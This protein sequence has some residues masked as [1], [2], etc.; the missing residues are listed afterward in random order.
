MK[1]KASYSWKAMGILY[2]VGGVTEKNP[3]LAI[4]KFLC[5]FSTLYYERRRI[6]RAK[7][8]TKKCENPSSP[9]CR[10]L[11]WAEKKLSKRRSVFPFS[12]KS[13]CCMIYEEYNCFQKHYIF[14]KSEM[15]ECVFVENLLQSHTR[16][17]K[18]LFLQILHPRLCMMYVEKI[19]AYFRERGEWGRKVWC[20]SYTSHTV[21]VSEKFGIKPTEGF[22]VS[23]EY[24]EDAVGKY[25]CN[26]SP[27]IIEI[28]STEKETRTRGSAN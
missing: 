13:M 21:Y 9:S 28:G 20:M 18:R 10:R 8:A 6:R 7:K 3:F 27:A 23:G 22:S 1:I 17:K 25:F 5:D 26:T 15:N 2:F 24:C 16:M 14:I 19:T 11:C 4:I 12:F